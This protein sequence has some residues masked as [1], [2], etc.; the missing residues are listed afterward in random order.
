ML[1]WFSYSIKIN[2][3]KDLNHD[4]LGERLKPQLK[5]DKHQHLEN[6]HEEEKNIMKSPHIPNEHRNIESR[7]KPFS[8][9]SLDAKSK[10]NGEGKSC[11][12]ILN[13]RN[14]K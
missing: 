7:F 13:I 8:E 14:S 3:V 12:I 6:R 4:F 2:N 5:S 9:N 10:V 1:Y 11:R